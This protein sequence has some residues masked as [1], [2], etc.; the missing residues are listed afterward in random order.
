[1][2]LKRTLKYMIHLFCAITT[3]Q[4]VFISLLSAILGT[5]SEIGYRTL[6]AIIITAFVGVLPTIIFVVGTENVSRRI[7]F[8]L[9]G[10]HFILTISFVFAS[11]NHFGK[12]V[13]DNTIPIIILF[14]VIYIAAHITAEIRTKKMIDELNK[15][16]NATHKG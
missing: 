3:V 10:I 6:H 15:R 7:Y 8:L 14:L 5:N 1:M 12:L 16:I 11:L 2:K 4:I 13:Q 9:V